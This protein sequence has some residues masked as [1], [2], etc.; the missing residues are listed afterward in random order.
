MVYVVMFIGLALSVFEIWDDNNN[1]W[2][3]K[4]AK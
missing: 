1:S 4:G 2:Y 3:S